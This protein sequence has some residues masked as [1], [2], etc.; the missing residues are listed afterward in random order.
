MGTVSEE[1]DILVRLAIFSQF[2]PASRNYGTDSECSHSLYDHARQC[3][4]IVHDDAAEA[5]INWYATSSEEFR[6]IIGR[7]VVWR[8]SKYEA[9]DILN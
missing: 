9:T 5:N 7:L 2:A 3:L 6:K 8:F 4:W 1:E